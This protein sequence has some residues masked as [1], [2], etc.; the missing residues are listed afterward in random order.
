MI[1]VKKL[2][3]ESEIK[4][5][6]RVC[7]AKTP[8]L[9]WE[10]VG[11]YLNDTLGHDYSSS[12]YRKMYQYFNM[13]KDDLA[14]E[15]YDV[16]AQIEELEELKEEIRKEK[17]KLQTLNLERN[18]ITREESRQELFYEQLGQY[19]GSK[20][21]TKLAP[22]YSPRKKNMKY[23]LGIADIHA[24]GNWATPTNEYS[25][26]I[27]KDRFEILLDETIAFVEEKHLDELNIALLGDL[28]DGCLRMSNLQTMDSSVAKA[29][30]DI[31]DMIIDFVEQLVDATHVHVNLYDVVYANHS[32]TRYLQNYD[33]KEDLGYTINRYI[34]TGLRHNA[35]VDV[36]SPLE[37]DLYLDFKIWDFECIGFH[38]HT[39][40]SN[41]DAIKELT[42][43]R[44]K[45][46]DFAICG[47]MHS[48]E[49]RTNTVGGTYNVK[50]IQF[51]SFAGDDPYAN[52]IKKISKGSC[53][54]CGFDKEYGHTETY[55]IILN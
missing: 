7:D 47:H 37:N 33:I 9:T 21:V 48:S 49:S 35:N 42:M 10:E 31:A 16:D 53:M 8:D 36:Y 32:M 11:I 28:I 52:S 38:G 54:I 23:L 27:V 17:V 44:R 50:T 25:M 4:Y 55:E 1:N 6:V 43:T 20:Q 51:P 46:Y 3:G 14:E 34:K 39:E 45:L 41:M 5:I 26:K 24:N 12:K 30:A 29:T 18:R 22:L 2:E 40:K 19:I 15:F 13:V